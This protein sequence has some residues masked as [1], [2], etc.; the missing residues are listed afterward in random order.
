[1]EK[2]E[3][4]EQESGRQIRLKD[5]SVDVERTK[6]AKYEMKPSRKAAIVYYVPVP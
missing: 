3:Q 4:G 6:V 1:M 2:P 5:P